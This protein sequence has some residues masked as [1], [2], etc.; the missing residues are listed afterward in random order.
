[1]AEELSRLGQARRKGSRAITASRFMAADC[2]WGRFARC[3]SVQVFA[4]YAGRTLQPDGLTEAGNSMDD[5]HSQKAG[6]ESP[7]CV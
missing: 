3:R 4:A 6:L 5:E 1:M 7:T 2:I